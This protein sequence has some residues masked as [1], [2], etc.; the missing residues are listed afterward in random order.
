MPNAH[1]CDVCLLPTS[2]STACPSSLASALPGKYFFSTQWLHQR[3]PT[4]RK[5]AREPPFPEQEEYWCVTWPSSP[6]LRAP[7]QPQFHQVGLTAHRLGFNPECSRYQVKHYKES[8][9]WQNVFSSPQNKRLAVR[10]AQR[11]R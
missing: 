3:E 2:Q 10:E 11:K 4:W 9:C 6:N 1:I 8:C 7:L 5:G